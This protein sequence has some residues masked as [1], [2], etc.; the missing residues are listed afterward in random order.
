[1]LSFR[2]HGTNCFFVRSSID[3]RLLAIDAGWPGTLLEY[4]RGMKSIGCFLDKIAWSIVTHFHMD[5]AGL[6]GEFLDRGVTCFVFENQLGAIDAME[7]TIEKNGA[8]YGRIQKDRLHPIAIRDSRAVLEKLGIH[9]E[10]IVTDYHSPD[11]V[12]FLSDEGEAVIG[13]LSPAA[14]MMPDDQPFQ[15]NWDLL[16]KRG[17]RNI[18]PSHAGAFRLEA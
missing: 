17:A 13:D 11:S 3:D 15:R 10:V 18:F 4:A 12:T 2:Y 5:H 14:Q 1:V 9:G 8:H 16:R 7:K 6:L